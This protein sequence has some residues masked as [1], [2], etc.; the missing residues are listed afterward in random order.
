VVGIA[1]TAGTFLL[2]PALGVAKRHLGRMLGSNATAG[3][4]T[5]DLLC[6]HLAGAVFIGLVGRTVLG[7]WWLDSTIAGPGPL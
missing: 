2:E 1:L 5:Q 6:A 4:G 3:E 7:W